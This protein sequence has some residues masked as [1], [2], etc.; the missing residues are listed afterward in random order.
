[1][2]AG[3]D[4]LAAGFAVHVDAKRCVVLEDLPGWHATIGVLHRRYDLLEPAILAGEHLKRRRYLG[5]QPAIGTQNELQAES[6][7]CGDFTPVRDR[8]VA[9]GAQPG[10]DLVD[11]GIGIGDAADELGRADDLIAQRQQLGEDDP[12]FAAAWASR[13]QQIAVMFDRLALFG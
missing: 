7:D 11:R 13:Q 12:R 5:D 6:V 2:N 4:T 1:N 3:L 9:V 10:L 8:V